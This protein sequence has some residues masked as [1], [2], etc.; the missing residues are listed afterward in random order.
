MATP[1]GPAKSPSVGKCV[2]MLPV[3]TFLIWVCI[4][5]QHSLFDAIRA[6]MDEAQLPHTSEGYAHLF[7][8]LF[9][10]LF[11]QNSFQKYPLLVIGIATLL[12]SAATHL[13]PPW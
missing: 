3:L 12:A 2:L 9:S 1:D 5:A 6:F 4:G 8:V 7:A 13:W 11:I 10:P